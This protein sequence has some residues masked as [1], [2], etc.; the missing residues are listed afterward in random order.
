MA[1]Q[2]EP[3]QFAARCVVGT[4]GDFGG[5]LYMIIS[6]KVKASYRRPDGCEIVL[7]IL[8]PSE[9]FGAITLFDPGSRGMSVTALTE[10]LAVPIERDQLLVWMAERPEVSDQVLRLFARRAKATANSLV[11]FAF[12][13]VQSRIASRL[14]LLSKRFGW[15]EGDV[16][17]VVHDLTLD[18]FSLLVGV[19][20]ETTD[21]TLREFEDR[22]WIRLED[23][24]VVIVDGQAL[25]SCG[26]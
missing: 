6:G 23:N 18:D 21:A 17:R 7:T 16:V 8:G 5:R 10:V 11:D 19:A 12:A 15:Q 14:M 25:A 24:S 9:I 20:P 4:P 22:G 1:K 13:D 3:E 2:L 26:R